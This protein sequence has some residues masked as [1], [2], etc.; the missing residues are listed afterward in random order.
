MCVCLSKSF[1][2]LSHL[3]RFP[4]ETKVSNTYQ[5][6]AKAIILNVFPFICQQNVS[7]ERSGTYFKGTYSIS[8]N[9]KGLCYI[10]K[11][12]F[13][14]VKHLYF[15]NVTKLLAVCLLGVDPIQEE[16]SE[17]K[18]RANLLIFPPSSSATVIPEVLMFA[19]ILVDE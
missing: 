18:G 7:F 13:L 5:P 9:T 2:A 16:T 17:A 8:F 19:I 3:N 10:N 6:L 11:V 12:P 1:S 4:V 14:P 15:L